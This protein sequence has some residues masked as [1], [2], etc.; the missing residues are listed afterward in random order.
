MLGSPILL[1]PPEGVAGHI[2]G[3]GLL[4]I[5]GAVQQN[6]ATVVRYNKIKQ[7]CALWG[8]RWPI[9][10]CYS[11]IL[12]LTYYPEALDFYFFFFFTGFVG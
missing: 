11:Q 9:L 8:D 2:T 7:L 1:L 4:H 12:V 6:K 10:T 5:C 3:A